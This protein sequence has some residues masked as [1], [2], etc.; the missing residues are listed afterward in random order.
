MEE[1]STFLDRLQKAAD[2]V[3]FNSGTQEI[4]IEELSVTNAIK[5]IHNTF[6]ARGQKKGSLPDK[7]WVA[8]EIH[9][10]AVALAEARTATV[11]RQGVLGPEALNQ[12]GLV[13][14]V[15][16]VGTGKVN[17]FVGT[18]A[19]AENLCLT[20]L[21]GQKHPAPCAKNLVTGQP[22]APRGRQ[23]T[24]SRRAN[25]VPGTA[26]VPGASSRPESEIDSRRQASH[27]PEILYVELWVLPVL[28]GLEGELMTALHRWFGV[29]LVVSAVPG[30]GVLIFIIGPPSYQCLT[31]LLIVAM[32][33]QLRI[34]NNRGPDGE[35]ITALHRWFG[36]SLAVS[37]VPG[38]G[39]LIFIIGPPFYQ[40]LTM[41][42]IVAMSF[43]LRIGDNREQ[44][45]MVAGC[46]AAE[47]EANNRE[48][49]G[50]DSGPQAL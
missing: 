28:V 13:F 16:K 6:T 11:A 5:P 47:V 40:Y 29:L 49:G 50:D 43:Q 10:E 3:T 36:V 19:Q 35:L 46:D 22:C 48:A 8:N 44:G 42:L 33:F 2:Q 9:P 32:S 24:D 1:Y 41:L 7:I 14:I 12:K 26:L 38:C 15:G 20:P 25:A 4:L 17:A 18:K 37:A 31:M 30:C 39:V 23:K 27:N 34:C 45:W 21:S